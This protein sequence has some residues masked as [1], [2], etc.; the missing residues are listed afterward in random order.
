MNLDASQNRETENNLQ[1]SNQTVDARIKETY[2]WLLVPYIDRDVDLRTVVWDN[3]RISG[4]TDDIIKKA[5]AQVLQREAV[6]DKWAP[7][8]LLLELDNL[9]W[10][11]QDSISI[12]KLW[13]F[14]CTYC[15]LPRIKSYEVLEDAIIRGVDSSDF[16][17]YAADVSE[18]R[19]IDLKYN[20]SLRYIDRSGFLVKTDAARKQIL[21][22]QARV[23]PVTPPSSNPPEPDIPVTPP[24]PQ[25]GENGTSPIGG[26]PVTPPQPV[27]TSNAQHN[28]FMSASID[29]TRI[30]R[31]VQK[32]VEEIISHLID[33]NDSSVEITLE[34]K[35]TSDSGFTQP[36]I[37]AVSENCR[38]L[39][40][41]SF[42]FDT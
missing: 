3:F 17:A 14:L 1:R 4:G 26:T 36:T 21:D 37:R 34:V 29:N 8:L 6:I 13:D 7:A 23:P 39:K 15:Y 30:I 2:C 9:L 38:T 33:V 19:F 16:F 28:F 41:D 22:D 5:A 27:E 42:G 20:Q 12:K 35:A 31:D 10:K 32:Y 25:P 24:V 18:G 40:V 11:D